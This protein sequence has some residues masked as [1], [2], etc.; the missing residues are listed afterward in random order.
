MEGNFSYAIYSLESKA[1]ID[2]HPEED[3]PAS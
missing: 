3:I 1:E 2:I